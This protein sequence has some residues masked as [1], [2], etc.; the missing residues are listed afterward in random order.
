LHSGEIGGMITTSAHRA[1][2]LGAPF[3]V[4]RL[5]ALGSWL[6]ARTSAQADGDQIFDNWQSA[7]STQHSAKKPSTEYLVSGT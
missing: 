7:V 3:F 5:L 1:F 6:L 2:G 4:F